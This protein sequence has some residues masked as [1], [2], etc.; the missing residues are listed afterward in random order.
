VL[1][2]PRGIVAGAD[3]ILTVLIVGRLRAARHHRR[4][5]GSFAVGRARRPRLSSSLSA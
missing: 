5:R 1:A 4:A 3:I 2:V